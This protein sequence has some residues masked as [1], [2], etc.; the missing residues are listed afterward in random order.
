MY[1]YCG[2]KKHSRFEHSKTGGKAENVRFSNLNSTTLYE[3]FLEMEET[4][5]LNTRS[6]SDKNYHLIVSF[7][8]GEKP[9]EIV[10][11][12]IENNL[13]ERI[14]LGEHQRISIVHNDTDHFHFHVLINKIHPVTHNNVEPF[15]TKDLMKVCDE[16]EIKHGLQKVNHS[17]SKKIQLTESEIFRNEES[18]TCFLKE[19]ISNFSNSDS[20]ENCIV[21]LILRGYVE[22]TWC[23]ACI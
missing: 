14:G 11:Q 9:S 3:A 17:A 5:A 13:V 18:L 12:D 1:V 15:M 8:V 22:K 21:L 2:S 7:P 16:M 20:W 23:W 4:Q 6:K 19:R 10:W